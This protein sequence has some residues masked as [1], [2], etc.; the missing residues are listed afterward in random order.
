MFTGIIQQLG[1]VRESL[2][3]PGGRRLKI[4]SESGFENLRA[5]E[6]IAVEGVCLTVEPGSPPGELI[7]FLSEETLSKTTLGELESGAAV[8]LERSLA[9]G[10]RIGGHWVMGHVDAVGQIARLEQ[11]GEGWILEVAFPE[12]LRRFLAPKGSISVDGVSLTVVEIKGDRFSVA[13]IPHTYQMTSFQSKRA[14]SRVNLEADVIARYVAEQMRLGNAG[15]PPS[16]VDEELLRRAG[17]V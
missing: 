14:G 9:L 11:S 16:R 3:A 5:G 8:N 10:D 4:R 6:S 2:D 13:V 12:A 15:S 7:F 1:R 17:F